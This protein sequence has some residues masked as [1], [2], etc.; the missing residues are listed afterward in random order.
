MKFPKEV[1]ESLIR[2]SKPDHKRKNLYGTCPYCG[3][4]EFGIS[5]EDYHQ[6]RCFR[7]SKCGETGNIFTLLK[8]LGKMELLG[9]RNYY[10][11]TDIF[12][13]LERKSLSPNTESVDLELP[14]VKSPLGWR[15]LESNKYLEGRGFTQREFL[16][17][18]VG[19]TK[20][21][22]KFRDYVIF[23][24]R[25][26]GFIKGYVSRNI[27]SKQYIDSKNSEIKLRNKGKSRDEKEPLILRYS[28]S[29]DTDFSKILYG[30]DEVVEGVTSTLIIVEG[31]FDKIN[32]EIIS[33]E[34]FED[35]QVVVCCTWGKKISKEQVAKIVE[36]NISQVILLYDPDAINDSKR[37]S[38][39]L[40]RVVDV[41]KV[42]YLQDKDPG[43]LD[44]SEFL[45]VL[46]NLSTPTEFSLNKLQKR[47]FS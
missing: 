24:I 6:F 17:Y 34:L 42:G 31:L 35:K 32:L 36:K 20:I 9:D 15:R 33:P 37:Y 7:G 5:L 47:E 40:E 18:E 45:K 19:T 43:D 25:Q 13:K 11:E 26:D 38:S 10:K 1:L 46:E 21:L 2:N 4:D 16:K 28:N 3:E 22:T 27:Q 44:T 12:S 41:V 30:V 8:Y 29:T 23:L 14:N 39:E